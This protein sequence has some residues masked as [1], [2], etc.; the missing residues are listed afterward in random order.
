[1]TAD[2]APPAPAPQG[3][4]NKEIAH[5]LAVSE[6]TIKMVMRTV[7]KKLA[8]KNRTEAAMTYKNSTLA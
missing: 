6:V 5:A 1:M 3:K 7:C 2:A 8:A 4:S